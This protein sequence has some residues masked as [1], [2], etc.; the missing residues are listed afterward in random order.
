MKNTSEEYHTIRIS[1]EQSGKRFDQALTESLKKYSRS[2]IKKWIE[3]GNGLLNGTIA[4][5]NSKVA[6]GDIITL[7]TILE[8]DKS[9]QP[10]EVEFKLIDT[11]E[12]Y[13]VLDKPAGVVVHPAPGNRDM[14]LVNGLISKFPELSVLPRAGLIH[15]IDKDTSGLLLVAR[16]VEAYHCLNQ[17]MQ[18]RQ[19]GRTYQAIVNGVLIAGGT[20]N[21]PIGR[22]QIKRIKMQVNRRGKEAITNYRVKEKFRKHSLLELRLETGRTH[23]IRVHLAWKGYP[24]VGDKLYGWRPISPQNPDPKLKKSIDSFPRQALHA[25]KISFLEPESEKLIELHSETP[26]DIQKLLIKLRKDLSRS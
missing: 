10:Q 12:S 17:Q 4:K 13:I 16:T 25:K 26:S 20:I 22:H 23:Q 21:Q 5:P 14:T 1:H 7:E 6:E 24:I 8:K 9:L 2:S 18:N 3:K 19:I 15:R 11:A